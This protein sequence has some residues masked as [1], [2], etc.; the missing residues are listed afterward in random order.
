MGEVCQCSLVFA[1]HV[2]VEAPHECGILAGGSPASANA[3]SL[4]VVR[5]SRNAIRAAC[6][7]TTFS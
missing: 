2:A 4:E 1:D 5:C 7:S 3:A 6:V